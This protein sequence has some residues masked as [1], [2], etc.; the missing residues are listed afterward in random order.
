[1]PIVPISRK[2]LEPLGVTV[3]AVIDDTALPFQVEQFDFIMNQH[4]SYSASEVN[5]ILSHNGSFL[6][7]QVGGLDCAE[8]NEQFN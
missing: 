4:E 1:A 8:L 5:R 6:T 3:V 2:K 7:Q